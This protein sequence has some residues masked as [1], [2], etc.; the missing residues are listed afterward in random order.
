MPSSGTTLAIRYF[1]VDFLGGIMA[2]PLWWYTR[3]LASAVSWVGRSVKTA[4]ATLGFNVW[5][6][7]LFVPMYGESQLSGRLISFFIRLVMIVVL[8]IGVAAWTLVAGL[9]FLVYLV[10]LPAAVLGILFHAGGLIL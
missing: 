8:G 7:N 4:S 5:V 9:L 1:F 2:F 3:G 6:K 10:A